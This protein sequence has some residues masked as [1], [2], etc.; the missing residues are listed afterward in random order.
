MIESGV[1][2]DTHT[3]NALLARHVI[4]GDR[5]DCL[6]VLDS[7]E[8]ECFSNCCSALSTTNSLLGRC[9]YLVEVHFVRIF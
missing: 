3:F 9:L 4:N 7:Y 2:P 5:N 6:E 1:K 8:I